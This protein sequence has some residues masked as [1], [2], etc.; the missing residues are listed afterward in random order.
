MDLISTLDALN[1]LPQFYHKERKI[2]RWKG[3]VVIRNYVGPELSLALRYKAFPLD[4]PRLALEV[5]SVNRNDLTGIIVLGNLQGGGLQPPDGIKWDN[6]TRLQ[7][8]EVLIS[9]SLRS[10]P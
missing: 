4:D 3:I 2:L 5:I 7:A 1:R 8:M 6:A 10:L 9:G